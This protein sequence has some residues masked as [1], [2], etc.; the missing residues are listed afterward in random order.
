MISVWHDAPRTPFG[1]QVLKRRE[2]KA[3]RHTFRLLQSSAAS[4][5]A[6]DPL[7]SLDDFDGGPRSFQQSPCACI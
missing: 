3:K 7:E 2:S 4:Q 6:A 5:S 1:E